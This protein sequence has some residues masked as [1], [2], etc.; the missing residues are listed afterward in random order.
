MTVSAAVCTRRWSQG[1]LCV[2]VLTSRQVW[3]RYTPAVDRF[4]RVMFLCLQG[5]QSTGL[6][7]GYSGCWLDTSCRQ[8]WSRPFWAIDRFSRPGQENCRVISMH[9]LCVSNEMLSFVY[10]CL[11]SYACVICLWYLC[12]AMEGLFLREYPDDAREFVTV[13]QHV[14][15]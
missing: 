8:V 3:E 15:G 5:N 11:V 9:C 4:M 14:I 12:E 2:R 13:F 1:M 7:T 6:D 10:L